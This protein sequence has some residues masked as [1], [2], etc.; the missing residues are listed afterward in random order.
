S[1]FASCN[2]EEKDLNKDISVPVS[3]VDL[4]LQSIEK[5]IETTGTV[6]PVKE[7]IQRSDIAGK[8]NL[9]INPLTGKRYAL[10]DY[11]N[12]GDEIIMLEDKE[13]E[14]NIKI[15]S[16]K[17]NLEIS[18]QTF[19]KQQSLYEKG[20]VTLSELKRAEIDFINAD[21]NYKDAIIRLEKMHIKAPFSGVIVDLPYYTPTTKI[22]VNSLMFKLMDYSKLYMETNLA[23]KDLAFIKT[24]QKVKI[25]NYTIPEDTLLG[26]LTQISPAI[27]ADTRSFKTIINVNNKSLLMRPGMFAKG[28]IVVASAD[29][30][31]VIPKNVILSKQRG[32][33]VF[34]VDKGL[35]QERIVVFGLE[36]PDEVQIIS[37]LEKN[38]RLVIKGFET[39]RNR[40]KVKVIK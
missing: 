25:T 29:S 22:E 15:N 9:L 2:N 40:S 27:D 6:N 26:T 18:K 10:G 11:V 33:T 39:L 38:D 35:A 4:K 5:Y 1:V 37:G 12:E 14:N 32:S 3:V 13:Y 36:N 16:L 31:I 19:E 30:T 34:V 24:G 21:Y 7:I 20:G 23:E 28:E 17:L 8:Y